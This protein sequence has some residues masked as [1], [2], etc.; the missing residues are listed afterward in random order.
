MEDAHRSFIAAEFPWAITRTFT[1][2][3]FVDSA[4]GAPEGLTFP[5]LVRW[6]FRHRVSSD[7]TDVVDPYRQGPEKA[8]QT[9]QELDGLIGLARIVVAR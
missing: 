4:T 5:D 9:A 2:R 8:R 3:Q 6:A 1:L 7:G